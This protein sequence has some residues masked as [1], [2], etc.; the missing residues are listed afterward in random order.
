[1]NKIL[2][3]LK[4]EHDIKYYTGVLPNI[5]PKGMRWTTYNK[6]I[7]SLIYWQNERENRWLKLAYKYINK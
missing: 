2:D 1:I 3:K 7:S 5:K 4:L 6:L